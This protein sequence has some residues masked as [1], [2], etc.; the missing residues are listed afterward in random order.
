[1]TPMK[2]REEDEAGGSN[3]KDRR[4]T[5]DRKLSLSILG[6]LAG[7]I[8]SIFIAGWNFGSRVTVIELTQ[9]N[10][11][12]AAINR[13]AEQRRT[14]DRQDVR[15]REDSVLMRAEIALMA[16]KIDRLS[17]QIGRLPR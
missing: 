1:M 3:Y 16:A 12:V 9:S 14:D 2:I 15:T 4:W 5:L 11:G 8:V 7:L 10:Q 6:T 13:E 17:D